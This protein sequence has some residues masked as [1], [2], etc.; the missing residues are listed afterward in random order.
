MSDITPPNPPLSPATVAKR[1]AAAEKKAAKKAAKKAKYE[2]K[3]KAKAA[4]E[5]ELKAK[6]KGGV[7]KKGT[8]KAPKKV[9]FVNKTPKGEK[10][11][12]SEPMA[13]AYNPPEVEAAWQDWWEKEGYYKPD[14]QKSVEASYDDKFVMVIPPPNVTGT[15]HLGHALTCSIQDT[16]CR[17]H[18]MHGK[19]VMW[20]PGTDHAG[21][22]TQSVVEKQLFKQSQQ[23]RHDLGREK[24]LE[25]VWEWKKVKGNR[26]T[27]Q[28]RRLGSSVDWSRERF[29]MDDMLSKAVKEAFVRM[30]DKGIIYREERLVNWCCALNTAISDIEVEHKELTKRSKFAVPGHTKRDKYLFGTLTE[31]AY[32]VENSD[33]KVIVATTRLETMLGDTAVA[34]HPNDERYTHLHGKFVV[35]PF[36]KRRIPIILD[37][38]LVD[39]EFG[40][41]CVKIT[42]AHDPND[43]ACGK[44]HGLQM[45]NILNDDGSIN[46]NGGEFA[47][48]MRFDARES[49][50]RL[51]KE[52]GL[53]V[54]KNDNAMKVPTC[55]RSGDVIEPMLKPQW[56]VNVKE[57]ASRAVKAVREGELTI[58]PKTH[59]QTWFRWLENIRPW[60]ISRQLWWGHRVPA[61]NVQIEGSPKIDDMEHWVC[62]R[63]A[64]EAMARAVKKFNV[65]EEKITLHQDEDVLDTWFSS[66]L[67]PFSVFG[68]PDEDGNDDLK[69]F[70]PTHML[71]T[72]HDIL[73]FWVARMVMMSLE[74]MDCL[75]FKTVYLHAMVRDAKGRKMSKSL[76][77]VIDPIDVIEGCTLK[78]LNEKLLKGNLAEK[79][80]KIATKGQKEDFPKG[81]AQCGTDA[82]RFALTN[83]TQQGKHVNLDIDRV[84]GYRQFCN[85]IWQASRFTLESLG[86]SYEAK[87]ARNM[88]ILS[89]SGI[90]DIDRW[91]LAKLNATVQTVNSAMKEYNFADA[92][93]EVHNFW[94]SVFCGVY[95]ETTKP[96]I[97]GPD[98]ERK[99]A[100]KQVL[101]ICMETGLLLLHPFMP[102]VTEEL[103]QRMPWRKVDPNEKPTIMLTS[104]PVHVAAWVNEDVVKKMDYAQ[105]VISI[106]RSVRGDYSLNTRKALTVFCYTKDAFTANAVR[107]LTPEIS[108]LANVESLDIRDMDE[109]DERNCVIVVL[110]SDTNVQVLLKGVLDFDNELKKL[111]KLRVAMEGKCEKLEEKVNHPSIK[112]EKKE[113][114][115]QLL[116]EA[117]Q[118]L[119]QILKS[120]ENFEKM[121]SEDETEK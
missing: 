21:I 80:I 2:A 67:F 77:N 48:L 120:I 99:D 39:M 25:K 112:E 60:C 107:T 5:A 93:H 105:N 97:R 34:I 50:E 51:L 57:M 7:H 116:T 11:D 102:F 30:Y 26:I 109:P 76:G 58:L 98:G 28:L 111:G 106:V 33:E 53:F 62:G 49:I 55:S 61:Y 16:I 115:R 20:V 52:K 24:F 47:G 94:I 31:F 10:K 85:K 23:T 72:G 43:F 46:E 45:I 118:E 81:I 91:V 100:T 69:A 63:D 15:L 42:P 65:P 59:E 64:T 19:Q 22:A 32:P 9:V 113:K 104:F 103:W 108:C 82:L 86:A 117:K 56:Y 90:C 38:E 96:V 87:T 68:W 17:W 37:A 70:F 75:P 71:E 41:G 74:L 36:N 8:K 13:K 78:S 40:T 83:Y 66:G 54:G 1:K 35:H 3:L 14:L 18:R 114:F 119:K 121:K 29:T 92:T 6:G 44:R 88:D 4:R 84:V 27:T 95:L 101:Q 73:F 79:E 12:M 110:N 89:H